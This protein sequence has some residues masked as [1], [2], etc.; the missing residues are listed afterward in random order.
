MQSLLQQVGGNL[1][2]LEFPTYKDP[3]IGGPPF[4]LTHETYQAHLKHPGEQLPYDGQDY[5]IQDAGSENP[6]ALILV[7]HWQPKR[8]HK[9]GEGTDWISVWRHS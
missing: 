9:I 3:A 8:T 2:C 1:V 6:V 5:V 4:G 7:D